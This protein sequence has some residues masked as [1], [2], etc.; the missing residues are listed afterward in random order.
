MQAVETVKLLG[1]LPAASSVV[2]FVITENMRL[3]MVMTDRWTPVML[4][5]MAI[6]AVFTA[7]GSRRER[8][9]A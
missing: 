3:A 6:N 9:A 1:V 7:A 2:L 5:L 4:A 8:E